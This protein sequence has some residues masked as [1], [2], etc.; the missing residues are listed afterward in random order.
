MRSRDERLRIEANFRAQY[1]RQEDDVLREIVGGDVPWTNGGRFV[2]EARRAAHAELVERGAAD[3]PALPAWDP[4]TPN[5]PVAIRIAVATLILGT[6]GALVWSAAA[7]AE[8]D[9]PSDAEACS[10]AIELI[11][12][13]DFAHHLSLTATDCRVNHGAA[14]QRTP[15]SGPTQTKTPISFRAC[16]KLDTHVLGRLKRNGSP[17]EIRR[18]QRFAGAPTEGEH[19]FDG[20]APLAELVVREG[21]PWFVRLSEQI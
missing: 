20:P 7:L 10:Q 4:A 17:W 6:A 15:A 8:F 16:V 3:I 14:A 19:C 5:A 11:H 21:R 12:K 1:R 13:S 2:F 9:R 18:V